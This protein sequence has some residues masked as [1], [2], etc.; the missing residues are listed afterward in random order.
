MRSVLFIILMQLC[1]SVFAHGLNFGKVKSISLYYYDQ[2]LYNPS[3]GFWRENE[4]SYS[5]ISVREDSVVLSDKQTSALKK[6]IVSKARKSTEFSVAADYILTVNCADGRVYD[7]RINRY[8]DEVCLC[9]LYADD[10]D[11][12]Y[13]RIDGIA[14]VLGDL[15]VGSMRNRGEKYKEPYC[16]FDVELIFRFK[17]NNKTIKFFR[18]SCVIVDKDGAEIRCKDA[19]AIRRCCLIINAI[20]VNRRVPLF[21]TG[22]MLSVLYKEKNGKEIEMKSICYLDSMDFYNK[23]YYKLIAILRTIG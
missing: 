4:G 3:H 12:Y 21:K 23:Q 6:H 20:F 22:G 16:S 7:L 5:E 9:R 11:R 2:S 13:Y 17:S 19:D 14:D 1:S 10:I 15:V 8:T 18:D